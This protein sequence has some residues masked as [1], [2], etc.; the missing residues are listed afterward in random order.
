MTNG[1][2]MEEWLWRYRYA[3]RISEVSGEDFA[4][5]WRCS[6]AAIK[7]QYADDC[8][9]ECPEDSADDEMSYWDREKVE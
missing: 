2:V 1:V 6:G 4:F 9:E 3:R 7:E 8:L 5:G